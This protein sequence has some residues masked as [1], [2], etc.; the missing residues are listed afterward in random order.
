MLHTGKTD[1]LPKFISKK[2][3]PFSA[4]LVAGADGK[5]GFEFEPR[6]T[7][8]KA[9]TTAK[10]ETK[11]TKSKIKAPPSKKSLSGKI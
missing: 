3:R 10:N 9:S 5:V 4:Y 1:L 8:S 2:G 7:K 6:D 11:V